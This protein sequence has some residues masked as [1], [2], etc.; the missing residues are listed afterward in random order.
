MWKL[1]D[2]G[3][4]STGTS[5]N[6]AHT[7][8]RRGTSS[9]RAPELLKFSTVTN[10]VDIW[11]LGCIL[12][13]LATSKPAFRNDYDVSIFYDDPGSFLQLPGFSETE[14]LQHHVSESIRELLHKDRKQ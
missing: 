4:S 14:F 10:K 3:L 6:S 2:L 8:T 13:E 11:G 7:E 12:H 9:Y 5:K 1:T